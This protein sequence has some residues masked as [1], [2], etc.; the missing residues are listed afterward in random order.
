MTLTLFLLRHGQTA[1]SRDNVFCGGGLDPDLT[2]DGF[3]MANAFAAAYKTTQ[4]SA[5]YA[6]PLRRTIE[7]ARPISGAN[8]I[9][10]DIREELREISYGEWDG[11]SVEVVDRKYHDDYTGWLAD[12]A[13]NAP[14]GG[15]TAVAVASRVL[16]IVEEITGRFSDGNVLIVSHK[17]TIR[18]ALCGLL[19]IDVGRFRFRLG[20]PVASVSV[21]EFGAHGP[22]LHRLA[23]RAHLD[24]RMRALPGT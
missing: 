20:C 15:E 18:I 10:L 1:S 14:T 21:V 19:G 7:T 9:P 12:P 5:I 13:W 8:G 17:A 3:E 6:G 2:P 11:K 23:D 24:A 16:G 22:L 4:W